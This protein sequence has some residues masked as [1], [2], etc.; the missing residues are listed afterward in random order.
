MVPVLPSSKITQKM[1]RAWL[2]FWFSAFIFACYCLSGNAEASR[3][4]WVINQ[5]WF[6]G[7]GWGRQL[8]SFQRPAVHWMARTSS[9]HCLSCR[10][11][12]QNPSFTELPP[13]LLLKTPFLSLK[14]A[15]S[16]HIPFQK[17]APISVQESLIDLFM[18]LFR[19]AV[20]Q[21]GPV[22][23]KQSINLNGPF[24]LLNGLFSDLNGPFPECLN[25]PFS[26]LEIPWKTAHEEK[27]H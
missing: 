3:N 17:S 12:Y 25:G 6:S 16:R 8:L 22:P 10:N 14:S 15:S 27:G 1:L 18:G 26:L 19:G 23:K 4:S 9:L 20:F 5:S 21:H 24:P 2:C 11:P 13:A 7:R